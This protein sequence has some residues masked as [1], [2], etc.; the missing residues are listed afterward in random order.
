MPKDN[1]S[2]LEQMAYSG[3]G[4]VIGK[5][6]NGNNFIGYSLTGRSPSSQARKLVYNKE[7]QVIRTDVTDPELLAQG[8]PA[9]LIYPAIVN[10]GKFLMASNGSQSNLLY[11]AKDISTDKSPQGIIRIAFNS[12]HHQ[13]DP[14]NGWI[15]IT[16]FEPDAPNNTPRISAIITEKHAAIHIVKKSGKGRDVMISSYDLFQGKAKMITTYKGGNESPLLPFDGNPFY[17]QI[18]SETEQE[19]A[20]SIYNA[21]GPKGDDDFRVAAAV[22]MMTEGKPKVSIINRSEGES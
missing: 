22:M 12:P 17:V 20:E 8:N 13:Y 15:D 14:K 4:I 7:H 11:T 19:I 9:L 5:T 1:F 2:Q 3:R 16:D 18:N 21:I 10:R 6:P